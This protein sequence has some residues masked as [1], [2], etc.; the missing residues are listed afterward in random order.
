M[1]QGVVPRPVIGSVFLA[2][3]F[4]A[5]FFVSVVVTATFI[6][7]IGLELCRSSRA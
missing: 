6:M 1:G 5:E 4:L 3:F 2:E 7:T